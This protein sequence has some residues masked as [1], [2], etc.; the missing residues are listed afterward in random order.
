MSHFEDSSQRPLIRLLRSALRAGTLAHC[1]GW[2]GL[3]AEE[4]FR[5]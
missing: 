1:L 2:F 4:F 3:I 5:D